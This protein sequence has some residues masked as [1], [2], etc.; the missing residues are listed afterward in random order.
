MTIWHLLGTLKLGIFPAICVTHVL[1]LVPSDIHHLRTKQATYQHVLAV[2]ADDPQKKSDNGRGDEPGV[3]ERVP[4]GVHPRAD[5][6][7]QQ[8]YKRL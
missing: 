3:M 5:V 7:F 8:V 2:D 6:P 4:H 1:G